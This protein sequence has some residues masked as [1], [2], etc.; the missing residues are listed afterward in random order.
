MPKTANAWGEAKLKQDNLCMV[1]DVNEMVQVC[2]EGDI[3]I[4]APSI[5]GNEQLPVNVAGLVCNFEHPV[6]WTVGGVSC[7]FTTARKE[8]W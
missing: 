5:F 4:F 2:K 6:V 8:Y 7:V 3:L 1:N